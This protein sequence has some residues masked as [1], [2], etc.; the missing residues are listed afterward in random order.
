[1]ALRKVEVQAV[2][3]YAYALREYGV[4]PEEL[5]RF[6]QAVDQ[7]IEEE[8]RRGNLIEL[9]PKELRRQID[10]ATDY[11]RGGSTNNR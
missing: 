6:G 9:S 7:H 8:R 2:D 11:H 5:E 4:T 10:Q 1:M 3:D